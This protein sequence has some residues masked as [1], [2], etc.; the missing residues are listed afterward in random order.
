MKRRILFAFA[1]CRATVWLSVGLPGAVCAKEIE[2]SS[3]IPGTL[4]LGQDSLTAQS[5]VTKGS[6]RE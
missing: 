6:G 4:E 3:S 5:F 2:I 1:L